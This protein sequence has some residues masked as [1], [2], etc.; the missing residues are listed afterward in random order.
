MYK[1]NDL[2]RKSLQTQLETYRLIVEVNTDSKDESI[3]AKEEL[4][5]RL[6]LA[7]NCVNESYQWE[8]LGDQT[9]SHDALSNA[10]IV[11]V[12]VGAVI[13]CILYQYPILDDSNLQLGQI[14][15]QS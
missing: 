7:Q 4:A 13:K 3:F 11:I 9:K 6:E 1:P 8:E 2:D 15:A 5:K 12:A 14:S 10:S